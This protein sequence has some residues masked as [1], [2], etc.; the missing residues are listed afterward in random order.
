MREQEN[1]EFFEVSQITVSGSAYGNDL[2][3]WATKYSVHVK[4]HSSKTN[5]KIY[6]MAH[7]MPLFPFHV[8]HW[9]SNWENYLNSI[10]IRNDWRESW[11][12][13]DGIL[14]IFTCALHSPWCLYSEN[15]SLYISYTFSCLFLRSMCK[16]CITYQSDIC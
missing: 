16:I 1:S 7:K 13:I 8:L 4:K 2:L 11:R 15:I 6:S 12:S 14:V 5:L 3:Y 10:R 9:N